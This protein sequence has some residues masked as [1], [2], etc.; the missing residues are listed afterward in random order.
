MYDMYVCIH[1]HSE[2][3]T[4]FVKF[5]TFMHLYLYVSRSLSSL[6]KIKWRNQDF[7]DSVPLVNAKVSIKNTSV[8]LLTREY[9]V[10]TCMHVYVCVAK[11]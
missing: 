7:L 5:P 4:H 2:R 9:T 11:P 1:K 8:T 6:S 10:H 3:I